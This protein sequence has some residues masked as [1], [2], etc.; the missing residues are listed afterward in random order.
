VDSNHSAS[1]SRD[2]F[3]ENFG[4]ELTEAAYPVMLR[5]GAVDNWLDLELELWKV[6]KETV[7]KWD[8]EWPSAGVILVG[9][10]DPHDESPRHE[11]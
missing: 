6:L 9:S 4:A 2:T 10:C 8:Q 7:N 11:Q 5:R 3:L 1:G